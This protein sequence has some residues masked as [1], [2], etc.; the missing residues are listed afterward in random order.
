MIYSIIMLSRSRKPHKVPSTE[1][2]THTA[3]RFPVTAP[4]PPEY[5]QHELS[6]AASTTHCD[7]LAGSSGLPAGGTW[8]P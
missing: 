2:Q 8:C 1:S 4:V 7:A 5:V 3:S 6:L